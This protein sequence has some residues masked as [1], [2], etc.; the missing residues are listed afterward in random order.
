VGVEGRYQGP[1][2]LRNDGDRALTLPDFYQLD[3]MVRVPLGRHDITLRGTNIGNSQRFGSGYAVDGVPH[4]FV[5]P[6][7]SLFVTARLAL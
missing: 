2:F 3:A 7:R 5:L 6:P 4:F 1:S